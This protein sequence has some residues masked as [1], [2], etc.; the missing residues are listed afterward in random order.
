M[1]MGKKNGRFYWK[2]EDFD[3]YF[4]T[5]TGPLKS[6]PFQVTGF[7]P[8]VSLRLALNKETRKKDARVA[9]FLIVSDSRA[10]ATVKIDGTVILKMANETKRFL[11]QRAVVPKLEESPLLIGTTAWSDAIFSKSNSAICSISILLNL[12]RSPLFGSRYCSAVTHVEK[13]FRKHVETLKPCFPF[14]MIR[15]H[16]ISE[17]RSEEFIWKQKGSNTYDI[18]IFLKRKKLDTFM[19]CILSLE[20]KSNIRMRCEMQ[21][22]LPHFINPI[23]WNVSPPSETLHEKTRDRF[24]NDSPVCFKIDVTITSYEEVCTS[25]EYFSDSHSETS[26]KLCH[27]LKND[28]ET[29][30]RSNRKGCDL[31]LR[32]EKKDF[33]VHKSLICCKSPVFCTMFENQMKEKKFGI[34]EMDDTD[35]LTLSRFIE[36]LY[37]GS[38]TDAP[39]DLDSAMAL[40]VIAHRYSILDLVNYSRQFLV[41]N[42]DCGNSDEMLRFADLYDEK[43]LKNLIVVIIA[44]ITSVISGEKN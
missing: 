24:K 7:G 1:N 11:L 26:K 39:I 19:K 10:P 16:N 5:Q 12:R 21:S 25:R 13:Q 4:L 31:I 8:H 17:D 28:L 41:L 20:N 2:V 36:Y 35:S 3:L 14:S 29:F 44:F 6:L 34:V 33:P 30:F 42:T 38:V 37:L 15:F 32:C 23:T 22:K 27:R 40:Y 18:D 9:C 43:S